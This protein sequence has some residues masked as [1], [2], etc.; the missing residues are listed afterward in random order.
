MRTNF[1]WF[2]R[3]DA[4]AFKLYQKAYNL[5]NHE[6]SPLNQILEDL[7]N[8][9]DL[10]P[11]TNLPVE[12]VD[13]MN[14]MILYVATIIKDYGANSVQ[15]Y[16]GL[17]QITKPDPEV[18]TTRPK[19]N[20]RLKWVLDDLLFQI[21]IHV[22]TSKPI[23]EESCITD[24]LATFISIYEPFA[25]EH[26]QKINQVTLEISD[27]YATFVANAKSNVIDFRSIVDK[28]EIC[29]TLPS[30]GQEDCLNEIVSS[31]HADLKIV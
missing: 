4:A 26:L 12:T 7:T 8:E 21:S 16:Q 2:Q 20:S 23:P 3:L 14:L 11:K 28:T 22:L 27:T 15:S 10:F 5:I 24:M 17:T 31:C 19:L 13:K 18:V 30:Q 1:Q 9:W 25:N 6:L 29:A